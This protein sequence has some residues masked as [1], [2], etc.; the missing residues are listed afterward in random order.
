M[1][2]L[3]W[4]ILWF[5]WAKRQIACTL[6]DDMHRKRKNC[7]ENILWRQIYGEVTEWTVTLKSRKAH[8]FLT[9]NVIDMEDFCREI[10]LTNELN[11]VLKYSQNILNISTASNT[12]WMFFFQVFHFFE[13]LLILTSQD[14]KD[15]RTKHEW[16][17]I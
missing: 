17:E 14:K 11:K 16:P 15:E 10:P 12:K 1:V 2:L 3:L 9:Q 4:W 6:S 13:T 7:M 8:T 5:C